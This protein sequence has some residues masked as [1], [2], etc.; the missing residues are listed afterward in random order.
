MKKSG[1]EIEE[2]Q[3]KLEEAEKK[4]KMLAEITLPYLPK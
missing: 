2:L 1:R 4:L 3:L